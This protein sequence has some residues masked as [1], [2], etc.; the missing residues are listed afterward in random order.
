[1]KYKYINKDIGICFPNIYKDDID[2]FRKQNDPLDLNE[3]KHVEN[4]YNCIINENNI[5]K[6]II[7]VKNLLEYLINTK[8]VTKVT[9]N[10]LN[11]TCK[12]LIC[13]KK[14][15]NCSNK[16]NK[17]NSK[18]INIFN[19]FLKNGIYGFQIKQ[20]LYDELL[21]NV[22][23][24]IKYLKVL[25]KPKME[26]YER[27]YLLER[28]LKL[29]EDTLKIIHK[30]L[31]DNDIFNIAKKYYNCKFSLDGAILHRSTDEDE[32]CIQTL[33]D[34][35]KNNPPRHKNCH[36][37]PKLNIKCMIYLSKVGHNDGAFHYVAGSHLYKK[38][39][40]VL[41]NIAK[42]NN[43]YNINNN[44]N[45]RRDFLCLPKKFQNSSNFGNYIL[46]DSKNGIYLKKKLLPLTSDFGNLILFDPDGIH[47]GGN[48]NGGERIAIQVILKPLI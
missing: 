11:D 23:S 2:W 13:E 7:L 19:T 45:K 38:D 25:K 43:V 35:I 14:L 26:I 39:N 5:D 31:V 22:D 18:D 9:K 37:D 34:L 47:M 21:L 40:I 32:H 3:R 10:V 12:L 33:N 8:K 36:I 44:S 1:M 24:K 17:N 41:R 15:I 42:A 6:Q 29:E 20:N 30:I 27:G 46:N 16:V 28:T 48:T 4:I